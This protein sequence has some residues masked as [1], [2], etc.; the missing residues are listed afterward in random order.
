M[1]LVY[2]IQGYDAI[3]ETLSAA[4]RKTIEDGV[5]RPMVRFLSIGPP[6]TFD[7]IHN[8]AT[9]AMAAVGMTGYV[10]ASPAR[11]TRRCSD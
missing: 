1:W 7:Q 4:E 6:Q 11:S 8:H 9:W 3:H 2:A 10:L 5:F